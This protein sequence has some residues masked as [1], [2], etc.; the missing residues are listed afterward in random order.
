MTG[1]PVLELV[2]PLTPTPYQCRR[3]RDLLG[4]TQKRLAGEAELTSRT[5]GN[6]ER[7]TPRT[8]STTAGLITRALAAAG[9]E[10]LADGT[11]RLGERRRA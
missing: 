10:F 4:W 9:I 3:A 8:W 7:D 11:V 6:F 2:E 5:L 1:A